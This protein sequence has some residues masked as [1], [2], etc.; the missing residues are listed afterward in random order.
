MS[1][2]LPTTPFSPLAITP[3]DTPAYLRLRQVCLVAPELAP[4]VAAVQAVF[5]LPICHRDPHVA[6]FGLE[7]ALFALGESFLEIVAP[8]RPDTAA[9]RF[10]QR[11]GGLGGY[12]LIFD[13]DDPAPY[14][15]RAGAA[16]VR[17]AYEIDHPG[18]R[19]R[20]AL[21]EATRASLARDLAP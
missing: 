17:V 18:Y 2:T 9:G 11:S 10:L 21:S 3:V 12:M 6:A 13:C 14:R 19:H 5:G 1:L 8:T 7:N 16:G 20:V 15:A 4:A